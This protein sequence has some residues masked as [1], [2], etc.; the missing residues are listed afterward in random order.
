MK[1]LIII[2]LAILSV[3]C[4]SSKPKYMNDK[5]YNQY[6]SYQPKIDRTAEL[7]QKAKSVYCE[8][9]AVK[10]FGV[11]AMSSWIT[12]ADGSHFTLSHKRY[13]P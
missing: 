10:N 1:T 12:C 13:N 9:Q 8:G 11:G 3:G 2:T 6:V 4:A 5:E 7:F